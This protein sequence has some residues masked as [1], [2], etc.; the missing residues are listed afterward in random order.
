[1]KCLEG[2]GHGEVGHD[3]V[4]EVGRGWI[5]QNFVNQDKKFAFYSRKPTIALSKVV[6]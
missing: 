2:A 6:T 1:M 5:K 4:R 3:E